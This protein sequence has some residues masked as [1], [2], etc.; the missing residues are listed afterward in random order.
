MKYLSFV[1]VF[2]LL[3][4][5]AYTQTPTAIFIKKVNPNA[6]F[7]NVSNRAWW[8]EDVVYQ[9]YPRSFKDSNGDGIGD[10]KGI[11]SELDYIKDLGINTVW[12]N[13]IYSS[14]NFDN[15]YDVSDYQNIM[16]DF[17][18]M[19]DFNLLLKGL[20]Q[21]GIKLVM[22][23]VVNHTSWQHNWFKQSR[24]SRNNPYRN[25]YHWWPAEKGKPTPRWS[26]FDVNN[27]A[28]MYD[29]Q[30]NAYYLHYFAHQQP[31]LNWENPRVRQEVYKIMRFWLNKGV[32]GFRMDAFQYISKDTTFPKFPDGYQKNAQKYYGNGPHLHAYLKEMNREV[33]SKYN[34]MTV[35]EGAGTSPQDAMKFVDPARHE[36]NMAY[37]FE[38]MNVGLLPDAPYATPDAK[39]YSLPQFKKVYTLWD[40]GFEQKG[41]GTIY[42][43]N[44]DQPR[45]VSRWGNDDRQ[46]REASSKLLSTF[47]LS[48]RGTVYYYAGDELGMTNIRF[49]NIKDYRDIGTINQYLHQKETGGDLPKY[50]E[51]Q[52][53]ISRDNGRTP[54]QWNSQKNAGF[55]TGM[56]WLKVNPNYTLVNAENENKDPNS[57]LN[58]F[59]K[60]VELHKSSPALV[61][62]KYQVYDINNPSV[63]AY[64]RIQD[65]DQMLILLN[66]S[67]KPVV[68]QISSSIVYKSLKQKINNYPYAKI[69]DHTITMM[70]WQ[71]VIYQLL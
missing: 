56:P 29:K 17:G 33:L 7:K 52:K 34:M 11:I 30:T 71:A 25:Y 46:Y 38:G 10:L 58:Y 22:D 64:T 16:K 18:T 62:G 47:L 13:P 2:C 4:V 3:S 55:S 57:I 69:N 6:A 15:G 42:L 50:L 21:R 48:M 28:W 14:P 61:Y 44:H 1:T 41:W 19:D 59:R 37:H 39:G 24:S 32:D 68:Y 40:Q 70:P 12:L 43:G 65:K 5:V 23:L 35:A 66:F 54:F 31:D 36:L 45:M 53:L 51:V 63:Y 27:D 9:M 8:K 49:N 67:N 20:H 60:M 26:F